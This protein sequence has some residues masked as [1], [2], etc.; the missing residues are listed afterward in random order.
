MFGKNPVRKYEAHA[1]GRVQVHEIFY[2]LQGEGPF[3]GQPAV[4]V[5]LSGCN[6]RCWFC[7]TK[8][9][10]EGDPVL[11]C[12]EVLDR[13][14]KA[15]MGDTRSLRTRL[16]V[17]TG[18]EPLRQDVRKLVEQLVGTGFR[19]QIETAGT[20]WQDWLGEQ[21]PPSVTVVVSP[22]T[23]TINERLSN[24][25][26]AFK[27]VISAAGF[28]DSDGLPIGSTQRNGTFLPLARPGR[29]RVPVFLSPMDEYNV[30]KNA[31]NLRRVG[32]LALKHGYT[33]GIQLHKLLE[34]P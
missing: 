31:A 11:G 9:D 7:D 2:T 10:D 13:V 8:W 29:R 25:A 21:M 33:A 24:R 1:D 34:L 15:S 23:P 28:L 16:V 32:E 27:Y 18:G 5:R 19:V 3:A 6:L 26:D 22:K 12:G 17:L 4:F 20:L 14:I 30:D